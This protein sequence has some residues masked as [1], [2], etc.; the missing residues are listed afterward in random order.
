MTS[1][2]EVKAGLAGTFLMAV[3]GGASNSAA[4][5]TN[6]AHCSSPSENVSS[7]GN[8]FGRIL[9]KS[10]GFPQEDEIEE[11]TESFSGETSSNQKLMDKLG[12][13]DTRFWHQLKQN[14]STM[15]IYQYQKQNYQLSP[16]AEDY[17][18][19]LVLHSRNRQLKACRT[20]FL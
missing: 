13:E 17:K 3:N 9:C 14:L 19:T 7:Y 16:Y 1:K 5:E 15:Y 6:E 2:S 20:K 8:N 10:G 18:E 11:S 4:F 12:T